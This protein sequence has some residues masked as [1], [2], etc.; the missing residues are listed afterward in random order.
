[1]ANLMTGSKTAVN[2]LIH[3]L[4]AGVLRTCWHNQS[5][6]GILHLSPEAIEKSEPPDLLRTGLEDSTGAISSV[7]GTME[8]M[9]AC[10]TLDWLSLP[11]VLTVKTVATGSL[12]EAPDQVGGKMS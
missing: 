8:T 10:S 5:H 2:F 9:R 1:M 4:Q 3:M 11:A 6:I 12:R 7:L